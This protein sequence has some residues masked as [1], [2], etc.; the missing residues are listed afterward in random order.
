MDHAVDRIAT[1][2]AP[3]DIGLNGDLDGSVVRLFFIATAWFID[4]NL[5]AHSVRS[6]FVALLVTYSCRWRDGD[7]RDD[8]IIIVA[9]RGVSDTR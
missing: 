7:G 9:G 1:F 3:G 6:G 5:N 2:G 4:F 8:L